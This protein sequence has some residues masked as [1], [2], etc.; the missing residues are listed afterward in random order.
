MALAFRAVSYTHLLGL[1]GQGLDHGCEDGQTH[2]YG[3]D[4]VEDRLLILLHVLVVGQGQGFHDSQQGDQIAVDP[5]S[6][7]HLD[8]YKRQGERTKKAAAAMV[9]AF[10]W[11][12]IFPVAG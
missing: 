1:D 10:G 11:R 6:Y 5:V 7:T 12:I 3:V 8:V 2:L 4:G 9:A